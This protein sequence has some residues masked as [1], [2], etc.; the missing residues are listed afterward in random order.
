[1]RSSHLLCDPG[2]RRSVGERSRPVPRTSTI[3]AIER[4]MDGL[5]S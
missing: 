1:V 5:P 2:L 3:P 4:R